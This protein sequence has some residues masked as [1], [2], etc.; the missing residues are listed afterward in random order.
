MSTLSTSS[1]EFFEAKYRGGADPWNFA[2]DA[3]EQARYR[4]ILQALSP[5]R[6]HHA[7]EPGCSVA[8]LT[9]Q[10]AAI[11]DRV[12]ACDFSTTAV[13]QAQERCAGLPGVH[14]HCASLTDEAPIADF[15]LIVLSEIGYYFTADEWQRQVSRI[16]GAM[17]PNATLLAAHWLGHSQDHIQ[18]G[19]AVHEALLAQPGLQHEHAERHEQTNSGFR[20]DRFR[21]QAGTNA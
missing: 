10:L 1:P 16:V 6:Y 15:D 17:Q 4:T 7:W 21:K 18:G 14:V 13:Q 12:D 2:A 19:D 3:Y 5:A 11:C 20:L 9:Q 8:V